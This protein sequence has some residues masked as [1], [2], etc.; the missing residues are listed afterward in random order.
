A[1]LRLH[2]LFIAAAAMSL[3]LIALMPH[4]AM[5]NGLLCLPVVLGYASLLILIGRTRRGQALLHPLACAGRL[6]FT[7]Y[8]CQS[9]IMTAI[10]YGGRGPGLYGD[11]AYAR[12][13]P[14]VLGVWVA[15]LLFSVLW[16][17]WFRYGPFEWLW[18]RLTLGRR[19][20]IRA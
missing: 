1:P 5:V 16:L 9:L 13:V 17:R 20:P 19:V 14:I 18:R 10:F 8:I 6:A 11:M 12:L 3:G 4:L 15:Q 2:G 7:N